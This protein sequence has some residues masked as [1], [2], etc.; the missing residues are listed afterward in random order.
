MKMAK[1]NAIKVQGKP[2]GWVVRLILDENGN[3]KVCS[4]GVYLKSDIFMSVPI[5]F[6]TLDK[7]IKCNGFDTETEKYYLVP[8]D[9]ALRVI[10]VE[11][12]SSGK[13][14]P[15][16][17]PAGEQ[18]PHFLACLTY[19]PE[20]G[21]VITSMKTS[22][23]VLRDYIPKDR[24]FIGVIVLHDDENIIN[25]SIQIDITSGRIG[26][27]TL[28]ITK[29]NFGIGG[30]NSEEDDVEVRDKVK[31][32][33]IK[34]RRYLPTNNQVKVNSDRSDSVDTK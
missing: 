26:S 29:N 22:G 7:L 4:Y 14:L 9:L 1:S 2:Q 25:P 5:H 3:N 19:K 10:T 18:K 13:K 34:L 12:K 33:F 17:I 24:S 28:T 6:D 8:D 31:T 16:L 20:R 27:N 30:P 11:S 32:K 15:L 21:K 23:P